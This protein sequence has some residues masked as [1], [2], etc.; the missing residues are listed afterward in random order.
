[1][2]HVSTLYHDQIVERMIHNNPMKRPEVVAKQKETLKAIGHK[3]KIQGGNGRGLTK[4]QALLLEKLNAHKPLAEY[5]ITTNAR[6]LG[7]PTAYKIDIAIPNHHV[8][9][10]IDGQSH[11]A[12]ERKLQDKKKEDFLVGKGWK[13]LRF[14]NK[15]VMENMNS[16]VKKIECTIYQ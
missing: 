12:T 13:V 6:N 16:C 9:I 14:T 15:E 7:Y 8:A 3:P 11:H 4:P 2:K 5:V 10:E 1:M